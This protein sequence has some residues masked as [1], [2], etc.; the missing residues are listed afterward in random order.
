ML[1]V[2]GSGRVFGELAILYNCTRTASI[3]GKHSQL[4]PKTPPHLTGNE[5]CETK[6]DHQKLNLLLA[7]LTDCKLWAIDR[8]TFQAIM[9]KTGQ[10]KQKQH[11]DFLKSVKILQ[12]V[13]DSELVKIAD[14]LEEVHGIETRSYTPHECAEGIT[15]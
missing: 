11:L 4:F 14:A 5:H 15:F 9:M 2:M 13:P 3:K 12:G 8:T 10:A 6:T 7:A 1:G